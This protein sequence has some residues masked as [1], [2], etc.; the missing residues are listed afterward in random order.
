MDRIHN[1]IKE[2]QEGNKD[3]FECIVNENIGL[4]WS[5][6]KRFQGRNVENDDLFQ[7][8]SMGLVK[9]IKNFNF[10]FDVK[11]STY[12]VPMIMGEIKR[13]L[14]D[15]GIIKISRG[16][17][18]TAFKAMKARE[19]LILKNNKEPTI[20]EI[21]EYINIDRETLTMAINSSREV[22]SIDR[23]IETDNGK[24]MKIIDTIAA[25]EDKSEKIVDNIVINETLNKLDERERRIVLMRYIDELTQSEV[26]KIIGVSQVQVSRLEKKILLKMRE[27][28][29][30]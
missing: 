8:G 15:D 22:D 16:L 6:V 1:L 24:D 10:E 25:E 18:E 29:I 9:A 2:A 23:E 5:V 20:D 21:A 14:R 7:L 12:A 28:M 19:I 11:F 26:A 4:V 30:S 13:F 3:A 17:K 27:Y